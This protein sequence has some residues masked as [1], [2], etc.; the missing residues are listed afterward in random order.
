MST[1]E[2]RMERRLSMRNTHYRLRK[3]TNMVML[4]LTGVAAA[5]AVIP[6]VWILATVIVNGF[7]YLSIDFLTSLPTPVGIEGGGILNA[8]VGSFVVVGTAALMAIPISII[9]ALYTYDHPDTRLG[10]VVRFGTD[11]LA[12]IPSIVMGLFAYGVIVV[13][14]GHFSAFSGAFALAIIMIPIVLSTTAEMLKLV[15][16]YWREGS[17]GLGAPEWRTAVR[18][19]LPAALEGI[20]TGIMLAIARAA[21]E[22]APMIFTAFGNPYLSVS[23]NEPIAT[24]PHT[25]YLYSISPYKD[26]HDQAW[27][28]ALVLIVIVFGLNVTARGITWWRTRRLGTR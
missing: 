15:P 7:Q 21:G 16:R 3:Y 17:L 6:L 18:V 8:L 5:L 28:A 27:T 24:L 26:K 9:A 14:Q 25:I 2:N 10:V 23:L 22:A 4:S 13:T 1:M 19:M 12:G 11:V 20:L